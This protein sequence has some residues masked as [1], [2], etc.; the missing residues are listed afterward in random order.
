[1]K[2][3]IGN[4]KTADSDVDFG[5]YSNPLA[6]VD[7]KG[8]NERLFETEETSKSQAE[9]KRLPMQVKVFDFPKIHHFDNPVGREMITVISETDDMNLFD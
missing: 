6:C 8:L 4:L 5:V 1:M 7:E 3:T 9:Q 2:H